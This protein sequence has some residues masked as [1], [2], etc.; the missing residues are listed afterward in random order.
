MAL[1]FPTTASQGDFYSSGSSPIYQFVSGTDGAYWKV[2]GVVTSSIASY[3]LQYPTRKSGNG[4]GS[5][6]IVGS[7]IYKRGSSYAHRP[8]G[9]GFNYDAGTGPFIRVPHV[10]PVK[11]A[12]LGWKKL[13]ENMQVVCAIGTN[14]L[15]YTAGNNNVFSS[16]NAG[17]IGFLGRGYAGPRYPDSRWMMPISSSGMSGSGIEVVDVWCANETMFNIGQADTP[18][19]HIIAKVNDNGVFK[20]YWVGANGYYNAGNGN[21]TSATTFTLLNWA[22]GYDMVSCSMGESQDSSPFLISSSGEMWVA[23][24]NWNGAAGAGLND[25]IPAGYYVQYWTP[26]Q[27]SSSYIS[28]SVKDARDV[29][30][31]RYYDTDNN[32]YR[33]TYLLTTGG[34]VFACGHTRRYGLGNGVDNGTTANRFQPVLTGSTIGSY[35][36]GIKQIDAR[37]GNPYALDVSG[38][39]WAWGKNV[40]GQCVDGTT[41]DV[42]YAK[43]IARG[44]RDF[45]ALST[46]G[47]GYGGIMYTSTASISYYGGYAED[48]LSSDGIYDTSNRTFWTQVALPSSEYVTYAKAMGDYN[49]D[50]RQSKAYKLF[51]NKDTMYYVGWVSNDHGLVNYT[52]STATPIEVAYWKKDFHYNG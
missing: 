12:P 39:L 32:N 36:Q 20:Y 51:T 9:L 16:T 25:G 19:Y 44:V 37:G 49:I 21:T 40:N 3:S 31:T 2:Y 5:M 46:P 7:K 47:Y 13:H 6:W 26:C 17:G 15:L 35:L 8:H 22:T 41:N 23:G 4:W 50:S 10:M 43:V 33:N 28:Q 29:I 45:W 24:P 1:N 42:P 34:M 52:G 38:N 27:Y 18:I 14:G 48:G 30:R 11:D